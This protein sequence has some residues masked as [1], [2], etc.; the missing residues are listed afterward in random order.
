MG[1]SGKD[2]FLEVAVWFQV[3]GCSK[4]GG[5]SLHIP[6]FIIAAKNLLQMATREL[7]CE[8]RTTIYELKMDK[9]GSKPS[10]GQSSTH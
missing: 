1:A 6:S 4:Y 9:M 3:A 10:Y 8:K 5:S 2:S 7:P